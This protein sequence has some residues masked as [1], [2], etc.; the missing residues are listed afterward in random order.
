MSQPM[1]HPDLVARLRTPLVCDTIEGVDV[2]RHPD[3]MF[4]ELMEEAADEIERLR[5]GTTSAQV[6]A[7]RISV[8]DA[9]V[10]GGSELER[11]ERHTGVSTIEDL[12]RWA[13]GQLREA[14]MLRARRDIGS[15]PP[16]D[17]LEDYLVGKQSVLMP[18]L[19]NLRQIAER[20]GAVG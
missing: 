14:L 12:T 5:S 16:T 19:A 4:D 6:S 11:W 3:G 20:G 8:I 17:E 2:L 15:G 9:L 1:E 7:E 10:T 13:E 18:L